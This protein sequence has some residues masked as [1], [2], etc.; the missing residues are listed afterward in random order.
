[1]WLC[2]WMRAMNRYVYYILLNVVYILYIFKKNNMIKKTKQKKTI[3]NKHT[4][5]FIVVAVAIAVTD[6]SSSRF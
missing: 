6:V 5:N 4:H 3:Q 1:M 2:I